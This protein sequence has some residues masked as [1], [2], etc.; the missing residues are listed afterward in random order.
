MQKSVIS[1]MENHAENINLSTLEKV[2][3]VLGMHFNIKM[4]REVHTSLRSY[5]K[6]N[7]SLLIPSHDKDKNNLIK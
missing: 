7:S 4:I 5:I 6:K 3:N 1:R 2:A